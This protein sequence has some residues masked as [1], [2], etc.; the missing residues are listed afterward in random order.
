MKLDA[1]KNTKLAE[2]LIDLSGIEDID[3]N[4][5]SKL[6]TLIGI[7]ASGFKLTETNFNQTIVNDRKN[8]NTLN[9]TNSLLDLEI[10][11]H[12]Y[13]THQNKNVR[14]IVITYTIA[15]KFYIERQNETANSKELIHFTLYFD[16]PATEI[17][18]EMEH[19]GKVKEIVSNFVKWY[20][21]ISGAAGKI[22][23]ISGTYNMVDGYFDSSENR[24][25]AVAGDF[26]VARDA[27]DTNIQSRILK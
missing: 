4:V 20:F 27:M 21:Q 8:R 1:L 18:G 2:S 25:T 13:E 22:K 14:V 12:V 16:D 7:Y 15:D 6:A 11:A 3:D 9:F 19:A 24:F 10:G 26:Y 23:L 5:K 17:D